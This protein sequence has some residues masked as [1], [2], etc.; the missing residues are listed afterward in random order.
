MIYIILMILPGI[1]S[2]KISLKCRGSGLQAEK[3]WPYKI[4]AHAI[5]Q[6]TN[7]DSSIRFFVAKIFLENR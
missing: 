3:L 1:Y 7:A 4:K 6:N 5:T 2:L